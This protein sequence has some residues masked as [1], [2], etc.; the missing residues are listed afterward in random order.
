MSIEGKRETMSTSKAAAYLG[1]TPGS[2]HRY[3]SEGKLKPVYDEDWQIDNT[4]LFYKDDIEE[5]KEQQKK[6]G[7]TTGEA[8]KLLGIHLSSVKSYIQQ[9]ILKAEKKTYKGREMF[10]ISPEDLEL[11]KAY[12]VENFKK[13][14]KEFYDK[15]TNFAWFQSFKDPLGNIRNRLLVDDEGQA[16]LQTYD[17]QRIPYN[18]IVSKGYKPVK[19]IED[20]G[21]F[22]KKGYAVFRFMES[23]VFYE[24]IEIFY[25]IMGVK[26]IKISILPNRLFEVE[27]K[28]L[29]ISKELSTE[30]KVL[31]SNSIYSGKIIER[32][33]GIYINSDLEILQ[34]GVPSK[35]KNIIKD[36]AD[37]LGTSMEEI[38]IK[39]LEKTYGQKEEI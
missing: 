33:D 10:F 1:V 9:D 12:Y 26:N 14:K 36:E 25:E 29:L 30:Q 23:S 13:E 2:I 16:F 5:L 7:F 17:N 28:P 20:K 31:L 15:D 24:L 3:V 37:K 4:K 6:P 18:E 21:Y 8:S 32:L 34:I 27:V 35:I 39:L 38:V 11:F 19:P 22:S